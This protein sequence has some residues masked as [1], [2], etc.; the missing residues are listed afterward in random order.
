MYLVITYHFFRLNPLASDVET[1]L[2][3]FSREIE[4]PYTLRVNA[5]WGITSVTSEMREIG[6]V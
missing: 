5:S 1:A 6:K 3:W 4:T 2:I